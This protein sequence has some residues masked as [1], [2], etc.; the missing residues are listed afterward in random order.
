MKIAVTG[1]DGVGK[2]NLTRESFEYYLKEYFLQ[3]FSAGF[4]GRRYCICRW[5]CY[6]LYE[7]SM[8]AGERMSF[9]SGCQDARNMISIVEIKCP[10]CGADIEVFVR[11]GKKVGDSVC[12]Q[13]GYTI[14]ENQN[15]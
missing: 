10:K 5:Y 12:D 3:Q 7:K 15:I 11:D 8:G 14:K 13:C 9:F 6:R 1:K 2:T 4:F